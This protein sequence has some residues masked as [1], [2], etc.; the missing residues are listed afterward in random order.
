MKIRRSRWV[1][2][3][4]NF[5]LLS[6]LNTSMIIIINII[7]IPVLFVCLNYLCSLYPVYAEFNLMGSLESNKFS[8][9]SNRMNKAHTTMKSTQTAA[10]VQHP[11]TLLPLLSLWKQRE[12][13]MKAFKWWLYLLAAFLYGALALLEVWA[14][15][16]SAP[17]VLSTKNINLTQSQWDNFFTLHLNKRRHCKEKAPS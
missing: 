11:L 16:P 14:T 1:R 4:F 9:N 5:R 17:C 10:S 12:W 8:I 2:E 7:I 6:S 15:L 3:V 13:Y